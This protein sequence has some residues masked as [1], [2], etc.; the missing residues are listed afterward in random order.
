MFTLA[1]AR[2]SAAGH[3]QPGVFVTA[4]DVARGKPDPEPYARGAYGLGIDPA[5]CAV[6]EDAPAGV[7]AARAAGVG[8]IIG[9]GDNLDGVGVDALV[10]DL[11]TV[12]WDG[13]A[14]VVQDRRSASSGF[15]Q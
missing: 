1:V 8:F 4:D 15:A 13:D 2:L 5:R 3:A 7:A 9:V 11:T 14:L 12:A 10:P 6:L